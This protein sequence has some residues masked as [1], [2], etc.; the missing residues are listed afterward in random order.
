MV[1]P[2]L[3]DLLPVGPLTRIHSH[4]DRCPS[5]AHQPLAFGGA[6]AEAASPYYFNPT[7]VLA[8][9]ASVATMK[10]EMFGPVM[11]LIPF[12]TEEDAI[13]IANASPFGV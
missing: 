6:R 1:S 13:A 9:D 8:P 7:L 2:S 11:S 12:E 5:N 10:I 3:H 4:L